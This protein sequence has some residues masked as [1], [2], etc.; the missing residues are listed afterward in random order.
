MNELNGDARYTMGRS[1]G[2]EERLIQQSQLYNALTWG[3]LK[4]AGLSSGMKVLDIGSG[5]GDVAMTA[6]E[7]VGQ[8]GAVVGV[9]LNAEILETARTR[10]REA[11]LSN[12]EFIVGDARTLDLGGDFD[13]LIGRLVLMYMSD[14]VDALKQLTA[15][16]RPGGIVAFQEV[17]FT[18]YRCLAHPETPLLNKLID[19][20]LEVFQRSG[21]HIGMG[22]DLYRTF[23]EAG[24]PEPDMHFSAP[25]GGPE[26]WP[27]YEFTV[28]GFRS[29]LP[30]L[31][32][33]GIATAEEVDVETLAERI[34]REVVTAKRPFALPPHVTA[35]ARLESGASGFGA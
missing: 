34:R 2:E 24:L 1:K 9:D 27:G 6:A 26:T 18:P 33:Y 21:A 19:W 13:A 30:L 10:A 12:L 31:E 4:E 32:E 7:L 29:I 11:G 20:G 28:N 25:V 17:D 14:P 15:R 22:F 16:L 35:W 3:F 8:E 23:V 5:T